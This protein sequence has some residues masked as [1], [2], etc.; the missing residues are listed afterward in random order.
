MPLLMLYLRL[1]LGGKNLP[2]LDEATEIYFPYR[3][4]IFEGSTSN[5]IVLFYRNP[6]CVRLL[7]PIYD[8][9]L[10]QMRKY[11]ISAIHLSNLDQVVTNV[12]SIPHLPE[13]IF[14]SELP[15]EWCYYFEKADLARQMGDW[16]QVAELGDAAMSNNFSP[17]HPSEL[18]PFIEAY[19][20][21]GRWAEAENLTIITVRSDPLMQ[22][23]LCDTWNRIIQDIPADRDESHYGPRMIEMLACALIVD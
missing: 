5:A 16:E 11:T 22:L 1:R 10:P 12:D 2:D 13:E 7:D 19:A 20:H 15:H 23:M 17:Y 6:N 3:Y 18:V 9:N 8:Q 14:G 4:L 21:V